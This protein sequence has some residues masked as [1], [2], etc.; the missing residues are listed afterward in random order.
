MDRGVGVRVMASTLALCGGLK[1]VHPRWFS[2]D[3]GPSITANDFKSPMGINNVIEANR[4]YQPI[5][6]HSCVRRPGINGHF[7]WL[8][9]R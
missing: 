7:P 3:I 6:F 9:Q 5:V 2:K 8:Y 4:P 1:Q